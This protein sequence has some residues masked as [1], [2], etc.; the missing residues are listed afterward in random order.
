MSTNSD[1]SPAPVHCLVGQLERCNFDDE[2]DVCN[3]PSKGSFAKMSRIPMENPEV[4]FYI[5]GTC[6]AAGLLPNG[7]DKGINKSV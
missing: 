6:I 2:C 5:C 1:P 7:K 3:N 4:E